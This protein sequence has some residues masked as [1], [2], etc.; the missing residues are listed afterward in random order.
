MRCGAV[1]GEQGHAEPASSNTASRALQETLPQSDK[2]LQILTTDSAVRS[3]HGV[4]YTRLWN[5]ELV[6]MLQEFAVDFRPESFDLLRRVDGSPRQEPRP[7]AKPKG[8]RD[9]ASGE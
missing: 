6:S 2:P 3:I 4:S 9:A 7:G 8:A 1:R 5:A